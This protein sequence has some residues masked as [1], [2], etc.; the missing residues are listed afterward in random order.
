MNH[1]NCVVNGDVVGGG[2]ET[3][4]PSNSSIAGST[5]EDTPVKQ[6][7]CTGKKPRIN[8]VKKLDDLFNEISQ[9]LFFLV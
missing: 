3:I 9:I 2:S 6:V 8:Q 5:D 4:D 1:G 7:G